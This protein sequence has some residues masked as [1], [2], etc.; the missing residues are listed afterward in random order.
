[1][2]EATYSGIR[3]PGKGADGHC[4]GCISRRQRA[5]LDVKNVYLASFGGHGDAPAI[6]TLGL[7]LSVGIPR[8]QDGIGRHMSNAFQIWF[9]RTEEIRGVRQSY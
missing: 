4:V 6:G 2:D 8:R 9:Y 1:M 3:R 5:G 7:A